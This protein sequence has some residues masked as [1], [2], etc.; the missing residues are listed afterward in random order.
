MCTLSYFLTDDG[1]ELFFNRDE[2]KT[3]ATALAPELHNAMIYPI[4]PQGGG[5][6]IGVSLKGQTLALLNDY[7]SLFDPSAVTHSR[8][9][10]IPH[11]LNSDEPVL[12]QLQN[13]DLTG[14]APFKLCVFPKDL[15]LKNNNVMFL[16][17]NAQQLTQSMV[18]PFATSSSVEL[19]GVTKKRTGQF[20]KLIDLNHPSKDQFL[21]FHASKEEQ[22][23]DSVDMFRDDAMTVSMSHIT[24]ANT[25]I[26]SYTDKRSND[27]DII[28]HLRV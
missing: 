25:I 13:M 9:V 23:R 15:S 22:G 10:L 26:F 8:G 4:D 7:Q 19:E 17:W 2:Q 28:R 27:V 16:R 18:G 1:Y 6:W 21:A 20:N 5:T 12:E 24:V 11:L 3:R 14:F